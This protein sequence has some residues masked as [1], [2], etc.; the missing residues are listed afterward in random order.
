ME[1]GGG[2]VL[3]MRLQTAPVHE[4]TVAQAAKHAQEKDSLGA[5]DAAEV[6]MIGDIQPLVRA[7][8]NSPVNSVEVEPF[9]RI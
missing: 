5:S 3:R 7:V 1:V 8:F 9:L 4:Q 2:L 6:V